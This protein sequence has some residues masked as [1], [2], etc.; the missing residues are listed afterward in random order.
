MHYLMLLIEIKNDLKF[1]KLGLYID[2]GLIATSIAGKYA[3]YNSDF[4]KQFGDYLY[5]SSF[6]CGCAAVKTGEAEWYIINEKGEKLNSISYLDVIVD[7]KEIAFRNDRAFVMIDGSYYMIDTS[8]NVIGEKNFVNAK[9]FLNTKQVDD[10]NSIDNSKTVLAAVCYGG[11]WGFVN[12]DCNFVIDPQYQDA[13]SF[14]NS[15]A[16]V[17]KDGKWGFINT[18]GSLVMDYQFEN[19]GDFN[20]KGCVFISDNSRWSLLKLYKY[21]H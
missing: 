2:N 3:Y 10:K 18:D 1:D 19:V 20:T 12:T 15:Y 7:S 13:H 9:P 6:N 14:S 5:A 16:A 4:E 21:N 17:S 11:K 8:C